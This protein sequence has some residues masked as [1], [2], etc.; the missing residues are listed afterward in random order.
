MKD[1]F[2]SYCDLVVR[3][4]LFFVSLFSFI[5]FIVVEFIGFS[6]VEVFR[7]RFWFEEFFKVVEL[8]GLVV[9]EGEYF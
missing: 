4:C 1:F 8:E 9:C 2:Y 7:V 5:Y 6:L 3:I